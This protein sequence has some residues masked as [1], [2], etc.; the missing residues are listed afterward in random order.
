V[1]LL[2]VAMP[3]SIHTAR[4]IKQLP[5]DKWDIHLFPVDETHPHQSLNK[6]T[7]HPFFRRPSGGL[8]PSLVQ[9]GWWFPFDKGRT[10][11]SA[12]LE[13]MWPNKFSQSSRLVSK[14]QKIKPD[15]VH[16]LEIQHA[17]YLT[18]EA[19]EKLGGEF[20]P[21]IATNW[22]SDIYLFGRLSEHAD[23]I[24]RVLSACNYYTCE[25]Q[26]DVKLAWS[27]GFKGE[28]LPTLP[29]S[30]GFALEKLEKFRGVGP[31]SSRRLILLKGYQGWAG[32]ALVG[33]RA[34]E[35]CADKLRGYRIG[36]FSSGRDVQI[37]AELV[38]QTTGIPIEIIPYCSHEEMLRLHGQARISIGLSIS[39]AISTSL[40]EAMVMGSFPIQS[41][42]S[43]AYEWVQH[44]ETALLVH[45]E[46]P[47]VI[48]NAIQLAISDDPLVDHASDLNHRTI[49]NRLNYTVIQSQVISM[50]EKVLNH[51][52][53]N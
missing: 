10:R 4:W 34:I 45:P 24:R 3:N 25:C 23:R 49:L 13:K 47:Q 15:I 46:D 52:G 48:A 7:V 9:T 42:T 14:I 6:V 35:L 30:G 36:V 28:A 40:L 17:G 51:R 8:D 32:R 43:C 18:L 38:S 16:S 27:F 22:G 11:F 33:L 29:N 20:P 37:A 21:W 1:K 53:T 12:G 2:F 5:R 26:R 31:T 50:Y 44:N 39:D 41:N 19:R